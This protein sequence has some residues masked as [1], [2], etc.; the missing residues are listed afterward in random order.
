MKSCIVT[1]TANADAILSYEQ[2]IRFMFRNYC[3]SV[4]GASLTPTKTHT[5]QKL[6]GVAPHVLNY[7][8]KSKNK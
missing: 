2:K 7:T 3:Q 1:P 8:K 5:Q 6:I 4:V